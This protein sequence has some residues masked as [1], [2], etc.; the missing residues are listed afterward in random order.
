MMHVCT[1]EIKVVCQ[2]FIKCITLHQ[3][4]PKYQ[5]V[6]KL[7]NIQEQIQESQETKEITESKE[8]GKPFFGIYVQ[9]YKHLALG[10]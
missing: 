7:L 4:H 8:H 10:P 9:I 3:Y 5:H 6:K 2:I 1:R